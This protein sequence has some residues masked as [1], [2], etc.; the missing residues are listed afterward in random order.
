M[1]PKELVKKLKE[2]SHH[3]YNT[4]KPIMTD[5]QYDKLRDELESIDPNNSFLKIVGAPAPKSGAWQK[6]KHA[7]FIGSQAKVT[8]QQQ[9]DN[10][11]KKMKSFMVSVS[12]KLD[13]CTIVLTYEK[14]VLSHAVTRGDGLEGEDIYRN[15]LKMQNVKRELP[16]PFSG[17]IRG[18]VLLYLDKFETYFKPLGAKNARNSA[19]GKARDTED[20]E[21]L[22]KHLKVIYFDVLSGQDFKTEELKEKFIKSMG[23]EYVHSAYMPYSDVWPYFQGFGR[24]SL[25]FLIDGLVV[26]INDLEEQAALGVTSGR[27]NGQV[28]LKWPSKTAITKVLDVTWQ[29][30]LTG[31]ITPVAELKPIELDGV[32]I[33]RV[34]LNNMDEINRLNIGINDTAVISRRNDVIPKLESLYNK[35]SDSIPID[36]PT[37]CPMCGSALVKEPT[38][39]GLGAHLICPFIECAGQTFGNMMTWIKVNK[40]LGF[41]RHVVSELVELGFKTPDKLYEA[42]LQDLEKACGSAKIASKLKAEIESKTEIALHKFLTA[43]NVPAL[44]NTNG[45]RLAKKYKTLDG[46]LQ[47]TADELAFIQ[48]IKTNA[49]KIRKG[50]DEKKDL[51]SNLLHH[52]TIKTMDAGRLKGAS[53]CM[54][55]LRSF[56]GHDL[57]ELIIEKG[58]FVK[59]GVSKG[60]DYLIISDPN[61]SSNKANKARKYGTKLISPKEFM[62]MAGV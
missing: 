62:E 59:S 18:E 51:I 48:G 30:G 37:S 13:G 39:K 8:T 31:R 56:D 23:L 54:T 34:T 47:A 17:E 35:S 43:L 61:S 46:V 9:F 50:L 20:K 21:D 12:H 53:F 33:N 58:G 7:S 49:K 24:D 22:I 40:M 36:P 32:T 55:G 52:V 14:G 5:Q 11:T 45:E 25:P 15:A 60:L 29:V 41:G 4:G 1:N 44:G 57:S 26:K 19:N 2:A 27:P 38:L 10:W 3:Y 28:A 16:I 42:S 6:K